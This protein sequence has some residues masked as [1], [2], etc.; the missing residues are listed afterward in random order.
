MSGPRVAV[1]GFGNY[2]EPF[3]RMGGT[4]MAFHLKE[5][6]SI[7]LSRYDLVCFTGGT[8]VSPHIYGHQRL[9]YTV[10]DGQR[11]ADES[12]LFNACLDMDIPMLGI[13]RGAQFLC[14]MN[15]GSLVQDCTDHAIGGAHP[16]IT[17]DGR[18]ILVNS[19]HHQMM[20]PPKDDGTK[21]I[22]WADQLSTHY[23]FDG[24]IHHELTLSA[25]G[26]IKEPEVVFFER[27]RTLC[28]QYHP[29]TMVRD[30]QGAKY[31]EE[32]V[33]EYLY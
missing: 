10:N 21:L 23:A 20:V 29:E 14:A 2:S 25:E 5:I 6:K 33:K 13:C 26:R 27:T 12:Y 8:D 32:I 22:A 9:S 19:T 18:T 1:I 11:D 7:N 16:M 3:F 28:V 30:T 17:H 24:D 31:F 4:G 15:G